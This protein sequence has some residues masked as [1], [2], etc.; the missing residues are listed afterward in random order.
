MD[1]ECPAFVTLPDLRFRAATTTDCN[2]HT[3]Q[4]K[5]STIS[6]ESGYQY[7]IVYY[8]SNLYS[9]FKINISIN[10]TVLTVRF[11][12]LTLS[13]P[14]RNF[15]LPRSAST[16]QIKERYYQLVKV[17]HPDVA[18][19]T[20]TIDENET[21]RRFK[22]IRD[23]YELL[24]SPN[25]RSRYIRFQEGWNE[26]RDIRNVPNRS[27]SNHSNNRWSNH[28]H[29]PTYSEFDFN[30]L[31]YLWRQ[32]INQS[33]SRS[34]FYDHHQYHHQPK[35]P[36][37]SFKE[38]WDRDGLFTKNGKFITLI[39]CISISIYLIQ[40]YRAFPLIGGERKTEKDAREKTM[41][42]KLIEPNGDE[43]LDEEAWKNLK[44]IQFKTIVD[45]QGGYGI[46][47]TPSSSSS[48]TPPTIPTHRFYSDSFHDRIHHQNLKASNHLQSARNSAVK[49]AV[50]S[51]RIHHTPTSST[52]TTS[53]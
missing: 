24:S 17:Y 41:L 2:Q 19:S 49:P 47:S 6:T 9:T 42:R 51:H 30:K 15:H 46:E 40:L 38:Q 12:K 29:H 48:A 28:H 4:P 33:S 22:L 37:K 16:E 1:F 14:I 44:S 10:I 5:L 50:F 36:P 8:T 53:S 52:T 18:S 21:N 27:W 11:P 43:R 31:S 3:S 39:G 25:R 13:N 45:P 26:N 34:G 23:A 35:D 7:P 32:F 20:K